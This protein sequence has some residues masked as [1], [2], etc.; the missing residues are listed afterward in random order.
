MSFG[1]S[2]NQELDLDNCEGYIESLSGA[3]SRII[4]FK[5]LLNA[6]RRRC[7]CSVCGGGPI[8]VHEDIYRREGL[9]TYP[10]LYCPS[11]E[12]RDYINYSHGSTNSSSA[13]T[14]IS[15]DDVLHDGPSTA[16]VHQCLCEVCG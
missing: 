13:N 7:L 4:E 15:A 8:E 11:C 6:L 5:G 14:H 1:G 12:G 10:Y 3:G 9:V 2:E 16:C